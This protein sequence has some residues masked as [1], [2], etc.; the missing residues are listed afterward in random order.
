[1]KSKNTE[2]NKSKEKK[3]K[4][5]HNWFYEL[6]RWGALS[7]F[8]ICVI[9]I[10]VKSAMPGAQSGQQSG[11]VADVIQ[12]GINDGYDKENLIDINNFNFSIDPYKIGRARLNS[13]H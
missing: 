5:K 11:D 13:S 9:V 12:G 2:D 7:V 6:I 3:S 8:I 10:C 1:M 4:I